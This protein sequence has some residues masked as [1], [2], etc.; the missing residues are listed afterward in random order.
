ME[1][2]LLRL[3]NVSKYYVNGKNVVVGLQQVNLSFHRGEFVAVTGE[4]GSGKST[5]GKILA[6][7]LPYESGQMYVNSSPT[8]HFNG[9]DWERYRRQQVAFISQDYGILPGVTVWDHVLSALRMSGISPELWEEKGRQILETVE[10]WDLRRRRGGKL[11]SG[12]KQRLAIARAMA[13]PSS[14]LIADE[15]TGNLDRENSQKVLQLLAL[16]AKERLVI[17]I[18]HEF[19]EAEPYVTRH[20]R[21]HDGRVSTNTALRDPRKPEISAGVKTRDR[22]LIP[23]IAGL[24]LRSRPL[25]SAMVLLFFALTAFA[26]FAFV[27][28]FLSALDD[29]SI[30][31]Y[32]SEAFL[33]GDQKRIVAVRKDGGDMTPEDFEKMLA[34]KQV[35]QIEPYG[36]V[37]DMFCAWREGVDYLR[38]HAVHNYGTPIEPLYMSVDSVEICNGGSFVQTIPVVK[39]PGAFLTVG[40]LPQRMDQIVMVGSPEQ[41]GQ[42]VTVYLQDSHLWAQ[43]AYIEITA[44]VVGVTDQGSGIY[45]HESVGKMLTL[46]HHGADYVYMPVYED[47]YSRLDYVNYVD[48][49]TEVCFRTD[50]VP[51]KN[52]VLRPMEAEECLISHRMYHTLVDERSF[53]DQLFMQQVGVY[54]FLYQYGSWKLES[55][56]NKVVGLHTSTLRNLLGVRA[57]VFEAQISSQMEGSGDQVSLTIT[58]YA[59]TQRVIDALNRAGYYAV[60][61]YV[62]GAVGVN[63]E[64][65]AKR[66]QTLQISLGAL[67]AVLAL[68]ILLLRAMFSVQTASYSI[69]SHQGLPCGTAVKSVL[70]QVISFTALGQL[71]A[72]VGIGIC[73]GVGIERIVNISKYVTFGGWLAMEAVHLLGALLAAALVLTK[74]RKEVYPASK[75]A[76]DLALDDE[77]VAGHD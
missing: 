53:A 68:Q 70:L 63:R 2:P 22:G 55:S 8:S 15:P 3:E 13:K 59:Y 75:H 72:G 17:V 45:C 61:P 26:V 37:R 28:T 48:H 12:Q 31:V 5:L 65:A 1:Q 41:I 27:G 19:S 51:T 11:S 38:H 58:D 57:D 25:W 39:D 49:S 32:N 4:S 77:E 54:E 67:A 35:V 66:E 50:C 18:T 33:N 73:A 9:E 44:Q 20:I 36:Y 10:L 64:L 23:Y 42:T 71:L 34:I 43:D 7:I 74:L 60:S 29:A 24:Q 16:A 76:A 52:A 69:L 21:L 6:G 40:S 14:I 30:R 56:A 47:V 62:I 46:A